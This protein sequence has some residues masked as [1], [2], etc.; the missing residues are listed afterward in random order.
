MASYGFQS[1]EPNPYVQPYDM[2][3]SNESWDDYQRRLY[4]NQIY[5]QQRQMQDARTKMQLQSS[6]AQERAGMMADQAYQ[7][8]Q[9]SMSN[10]RNQ[11]TMADLALQAAIE[12]NRR[13]N[14]VVGSVMQS[15][16]GAGLGNY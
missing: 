7:Q 15:F 5:E 6:V 2:P 3:F 8:S 10:S 4:Q 12:A 13:R 11:M 9:L 16:R 14:T 1:G